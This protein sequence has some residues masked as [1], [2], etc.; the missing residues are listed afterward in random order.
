MAIGEYE[1]LVEKLK[2]VK[3]RCTC[4]QVFPLSNPTSYEH[5]D[6]LQ[7]SRGIRRWLYY[8]CPKCKYQ[9]TYWKILRRINFQGSDE[10]C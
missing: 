7:D 4:G 8:V 5:P 1:I 2:D 9:W 6:G 10:K 3:F